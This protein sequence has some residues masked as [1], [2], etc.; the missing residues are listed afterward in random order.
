GARVQKIT[1]SD[2][3]DVMTGNT[4]NEKA[5]YGQYYDYITTD[6]DGNVRSNG[7]AA[8]EPATG[9]EENP[10]HEPIDFTEKVHWSSSKYHFIEKPFC[11]TYFPAPSVGYSKVTVI[12][13]GSDYSRADKPIADEQHTGTV[14]NEFY[15]AKDFP[16]AVDYLPLTNL[17]EENSILLRL[18]TATAI[19]KVATSQGFKIELNDMHGKEKSVKVFNKAGDLVSSSVYRYNV[20]D[21]NAPFQE[22]D[23]QVDILD[24]NGSITSKMIATDVDLVTDMRE[25][26]TESNGKSVGAY[27]G[28]VFFF[29]PL[30]YG[31]IMATSSSTSDQYHSASNVKV[32]QRY[33]ILKKV[34]TTQN[35]S[36]IEAENLLWDER[37]GEVILTKT[38]NEYY[39]YTYAFT[40]PAYRAYNAMGNASQNIGDVFPLMS[41][42]VNGIVNQEYESYLCPGDELVNTT[43]NVGRVWVM[44]DANNHLHLI[45]KDGNFVTR[46]GS[47]VLLRSGY[48]NLLKASAGTVV[49]SEDPRVGNSLNLDDVGKRILDAKAITYKEEWAVPMSN[50]T[51]PLCVSVD[52]SCLREFLIG[53]M[54]Y[55]YTGLFGVPTRG[56]YST[57]YEQNNASMFMDSTNSSC[58]RSFIE[59]RP[60]SQLKYGLLFPHYIPYPFSFTSLYNFLTDGDK[61]KLGDY[62][63]VFDHVDPRFNELVNTNLS[64][65][66]QRDVLSQIVSTNDYGN[67]FKY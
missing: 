6:K 15:T 8:Y 23:N 59:N 18:F 50:V 21:P 25:R 66:A 26:I 54:S 63:L 1:I 13:F 17:M 19:N 29:F 43:S 64:T 36:T 30:P 16:T 51:S 33:G 45:D 28:A 49:L 4:G 31:A 11:E 57:V 55:T 53:A 7:V 37:T 35:G 20:K 10:F 61:A 5:T 24:A 62:T 3:W 56:I 65:Q 14:V 52:P 9:N 67:I 60:A 47:Y 34:I 12:P 48:R 32:I 58:T 2:E 39:K 41:P 44:K 40:Y 38:Q 46:P 22:L 42:G 27:F